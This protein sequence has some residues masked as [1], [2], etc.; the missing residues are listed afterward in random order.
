[1]R[2]PVSNN[3]VRES[4][5]WHLRLILGLHMQ[6]PPHTDAYATTPTWAHTDTHKSR[7]PRFPVSC[8]WLTIRQIAK[9]ASLTFLPI[10]WRF[11]FL[12][13][14]IDVSPSVSEERGEP[15]FLFG[16]SEKAIVTRFLLC[17]RH[18]PKGLA[19]I[20]FLLTRPWSPLA[21]VSSKQKLARAAFF[22]AKGKCNILET[23]ALRHRSTASSIHDP[24]TGDRF[25]HFK[26]MLNIFE[27]RGYVQLLK[28]ID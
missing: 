7:I 5:R 1:M 15:V 9:L 26:Y 12:F 4:N 6:T 2:D 17:A 13:K 21:K 24:R 25:R 16:H 10:L 3:R 27:C 8:S 20:H 22:S 19:H 18:W 11:S 23:F 28:E 14:Q